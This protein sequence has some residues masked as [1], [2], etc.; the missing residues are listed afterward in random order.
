MR[1]VSNT[2]PILNLASIEKLSL[3]R[4]QFGEVVVPHAVLNEFRLNEN[5]PGTGEISTALE[6]G[7]LSVQNLSTHEQAVLFERELDKGESEA[8]ALALELKAEIL[9]VD[10]REARRISKILDLKVIGVIG[11]LI[12]AYMNGQLTSLDT[13][14][15]ELKNV[16]GFYI[17]EQ[18]LND[19]LQQF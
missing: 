5:L 8:I 1:V 11:I 14:L 13:V 19:I 7:W 16:A 15:Y 3:L 4:D 12:K 6:E 18:L 10:E 17:S 2:S 9:L